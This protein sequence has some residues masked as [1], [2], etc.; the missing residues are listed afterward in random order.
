LLTKGEYSIVKISKANDMNQALHSSK[1][2]QWSLS[3]T[4]SY[5]G[6]TWTTSELWSG[7]CYDQKTIAWSKKQ[8]IWLRSC[9]S[10]IST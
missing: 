7:S 10:E 8:P 2:S 3:A 9:F 4:L 6:Q 5:P 1:N